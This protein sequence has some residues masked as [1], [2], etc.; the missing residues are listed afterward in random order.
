MKNNSWMLIAMAAGAL[1]AIAFLGIIAPSVVSI[2]MFYLAAAPLFM[3]GLAF[4]APAALLGVVSGFA[5]I[6]LVLNLKAAAFFAVAVGIA[7]VILVH[8]ASQWRQAS[9]GPEGE[10]TGE[11]GREWYP[12][13]RLLLW[14]AFM[15][16]TLMSI[17]LLMTGP[18]IGAIEAN[19]GRMATQ[20]LALSGAAGELKPEQLAELKTFMVRATPLVSTAFWMLAMLGNFWLAAVVVKA[21]GYEMRPWAPFW[22]LTFHPRAMIALAIASFASFLPG[23]FGLIGS[24][25][26]VALMSAFAILGLAVMHALTLGNPWRNALLGM[27]YAAL[28]FLNWLLALPLIVLALADLSFGLRQRYF[29]RNPQVKP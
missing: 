23:V 27:L 15:G 24:V 12:E 4:G 25:F 11:D 16:G 14:T 6:A 1:S 8:L 21:F 13:G 3:A 19:M 2:V 9:G 28:L 26:A 22:R 17:T 20:M 10:A 7:P 29:A 5:L 18:G